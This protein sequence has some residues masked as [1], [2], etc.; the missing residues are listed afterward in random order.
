MTGGTDVPTALESAGIIATRDHLSF[1]QLSTFIDCGEKFSLSYLKDAPREPQGAF[2]GGIAVHV[3]IERSEVA[4]W[5]QDET[6]DLRGSDHP[7]LTAF[8]EEFARLIERSGGE[9]AIRWGGRERNG[10]REDRQWWEH[11]GE[12]ML[13]RYVDSRR[14]WAEAGIISVPDGTEMRVFANLD[15]V[16]I[17]VEGRLDKFLARRVDPETGELGGHGIVDWK[18]GQIGYAEPMQFATY[19]RLVQL[20]RAIEVEWALVVF[21]R[22]ADP[23]RRVQPVRFQGLVEHIDGVYAAAAR[24]IDRGEFYPKPSRFCSS[25]SVRRSCWYWQ[26]TNP[27]EV[28]T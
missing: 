14:T 4:G 28:K 5:W 17:P 18:T 27:E 21:L 2:L 3:A 16:P 6:I 13:R 26:A 24:S 23:A 12:F 19:A 9:A 11:N 8:H 10:A 20:A 15:D 25:C 22:A 7:L 1:S